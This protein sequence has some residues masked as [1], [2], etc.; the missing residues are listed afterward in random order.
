[1]S[2]TERAALLDAAR[3]KGPEELKRW[4]EFYQA[5][6]ILAPIR[7]DDHPAERR[8]GTD[9]HERPT[10]CSSCRTA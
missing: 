9:R 1:M 4:E 6:P 3:A 7:G 2:S 8:A 5:A 10:R